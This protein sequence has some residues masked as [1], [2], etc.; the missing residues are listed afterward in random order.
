MKKI[1]FSFLVLSVKVVAQQPL[2][3]DETINYLNKLSSEQP[4]LITERA[5]G[6]GMGGRVA[7]F[8]NCKDE[9]FYE[10]FY[11]NKEKMQI[12]ETRNVSNCTKQKN[13]SFS[14]IY[15]INLI[16][17]YD[18][19]EYKSYDEDLNYIKPPEGCYLEFSTNGINIFGEIERTFLDSSTKKYTKHPTKQGVEITIK[20]K[21]YLKVYFHGLKYLISLINQN[22]I[23]DNY[24]IKDPFVTKKNESKSNSVK[25]EINKGNI[26]SE[27]N[28]PLTEKNGVVYLTITLG[29]KLLSKFILDSGA[30]ECN[31]SS[32]LEKILINNGVIKR[33]DYLT[34]G[35]Y[36]LADGS[37]VENKRV[38]ISKIKIGNRIISNVTMSIGS[39]DSP[40]LLGQSLLKKLDKWSIDNTKKLL[41]IH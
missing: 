17:F 16:N 33:A 25:P 38:K 30:G 6:N 32:N 19:I 26:K 14:S 4:G 8:D 21:D 28:V 35:L 23:K 37:I 5:I 12:K 34:N 7:L 1:L 27:S 15:T 18:K 3:I 2:T 29:E 9:I 22:I 31:M 36:V 39:S 13:F 10:I 24:D 40:N 11:D 20:N 41:I